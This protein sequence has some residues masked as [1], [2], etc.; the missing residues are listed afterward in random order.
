MFGAG[1]GSQVHKHHRYL[2]NECLCFYVQP[3]FGASTSAGVSTWGS[4]PLKHDVNGFSEG[5]S[6]SA[7]QG[8]S[9]TSLSSI[10]L[11]TSG[12]GNNPFKRP[13]ESYADRDTFH[14]STPGGGRGDRRDGRGRGRG[15]GGFMST[16]DGTSGSNQRFGDR[17]SWGGRKNQFDSPFQSGGSSSFSSGGRANEAD[18]DKRSGGR[19]SSGNASWRDQIDA[20]NYRQWGASV[21]PTALPWAG[22][23]S[24]GT[25]RQYN[26]RVCQLQFP[27]R[28]QLQQHLS[29]SG[30]YHTPT[31]G[32][33]QPPQ[34]GRSQSFQKGGYQGSSS[35]N[36][37]RGWR[38]EG[39]CDD[40]QGGS[41]PFGP[42]IGGKS[43]RGG[44]SSMM[45]RH[46][47]R[48]GGAAH[49]DK[50]GTAAR[51]RGRGGAWLAAQ[52]KRPSPVRP[53]ATVSWKSDI[54]TTIA[55]SASDYSGN[56]DN[57]D[58]DP[59]TDGNDTG[60][61]DPSNTN[62]DSQL[63][64][65]D[66]NEDEVDCTMHTLTLFNVLYLI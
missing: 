31:G 55:N 13:S 26:C 47:G 34:Y 17:D 16:Q 51:G 63:E 40:T 45:Q 27:D 23:G 38:G 43:I 62:D 28:P 41:D 10:N 12:P 22:R 66:D 59:N 6:P 60:A 25:S 61:D 1:F 37:G 39:G 58:T 29:D 52:Q 2:Q 64:Y 15:R 42:F 8:S 14:G 54:I 46:T 11:S 21:A 49:Q 19:G 9:A 32:D 33:Q 53:S 24:N 65:S 36:P 4:A 30:H 18:S 7:F 50:N 44:Y 57:F 5:A 56:S 3:S 20:D 35:E 48:T